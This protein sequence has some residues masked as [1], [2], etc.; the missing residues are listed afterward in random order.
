[1][2]IGHKIKEYRFKNDMTQKDLA[3]LLHVSFQAVSKWEHNE[4]EPSL[5]TLVEMTKV[6]K[7]SVDDLF[8]L[9]EGGK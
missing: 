7:C 6:F 5:D 2:D 9:K 4:A 8:N 3:N 1:M